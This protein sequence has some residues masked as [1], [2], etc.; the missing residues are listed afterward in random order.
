M[1]KASVIQQETEQIGT[2]ED[3]TAV[4]ETIA[5]TQ[6]AKIKDKVQ[7]SKDFFELLWR[8]YSS[9]RV[10]PGSRITSREPGQ[11]GD[12][13][14]FVIIS[15][16]T[17]LSGDIDQRLIETMMQKYDPANTDVIVLGSHGATQLNERGIAYSHFFQVP[18]SESYIDVSPVINA[19][20][21]Y[22]QITV[23]YEEYIS[24]GVQD[25]KSIDLIS[26]MQ[27]MSKGAEGDEDIIT[28]AETIFEPSLDEIAEQ[29]EMTMMT[30]AF[31]QAILES[32]L[33]QNASRFNAMAQ[34]KKR[35]FELISF[36]KLEYHR[37]KRSEG[38]RRLREVMIS[39]KRRKKKTKKHK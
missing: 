12:K 21:D 11:H 7:L 19:I 15:A 34:A 25:I 29:M 38:D 17:G 14:V 1:R 18:E 28:T 6:V 35:A 23:Y 10:D 13:K 39:L 32:N 36:Q 5:S 22:S 30:L 26:T 27:E 24:L 8:R 2:V 20:S 37:S 16:E 4:F 3:L 9:I 31:S 33:A